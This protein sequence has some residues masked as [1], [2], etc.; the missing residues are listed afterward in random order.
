MAILS[1]ASGKQPHRPRSAVRLG[2]LL[3]VGASVLVFGAWLL[4]SVLRPAPPGFAPTA[5]ASAAAA[6]GILQ[7]TVD[8][9]DH[10]RWV[11]FDF[12]SGAVGSTAPVS[13][14][15]DI[16]FRRTAVLTN[17]GAT[18]PRGM[19]GAADLGETLLQDAVPPPDGFL[20]DAAQE[21]GGVENPALRKWYSYS[22]VTHVVSSKK[23]IYAVRSAEGEVFLLAFVSYYCDDGSSGCI[24]FRYRR[25]D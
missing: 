8:A 17:G 23:H 10:E 3:G 22:L 15:W 12:S 19:S 13:L 4:W 2:A 20:E 14:D 5:G 1:F 25:A 6:P 16:A 21:N 24:T 9:T 18:N 7:Y 11:Y